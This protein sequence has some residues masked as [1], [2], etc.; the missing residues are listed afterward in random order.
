[1]GLNGLC[2]V[3]SRREFKSFH[4]SEKSPNLGIHGFHWTGLT[5]SKRMYQQT[6]FKCLHLLCHITVYL[7]A[8]K[9]AK[10]SK[11]IHA[12]MSNSSWISEVSHTM[13]NQYSTYI[14]EKNIFLLPNISLCWRMR[15][16]NMLNHSWSLPLQSTISRQPPLLIYYLYCMCEK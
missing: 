11:V 10:A 15:W 9:R 5:C 4:L 12:L 8:S 16:K 2:N 3:R 13:V 7:Q 14:W 6:T 1:M